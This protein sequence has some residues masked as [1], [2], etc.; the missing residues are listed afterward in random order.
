MIYLHFI[1]QVIKLK[2]QM[3]KVLVMQYTSKMCIISKYIARDYKQL[4]LFYAAPLPCISLQPTPPLYSVF[5]TLHKPCIYFILHL[6]LWPKRRRLTD[7]AAA[8]DAADATI[9]ALA[10]CASHTPRSPPS[11]YAI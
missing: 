2:K 3:K 9:S 1:Y 7:L 10:Y 5:Q 11:H 4:I 6:V 8:D